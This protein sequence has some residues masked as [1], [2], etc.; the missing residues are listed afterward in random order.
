MDIHYGS[1]HMP[2]C[3]LLLWSPVLPLVM[4]ICSWKHPCN[5]REPQHLLTMTSS[6]PA[7][8]EF[9]YPPHLQLFLC[10]HL[11][12]PADASLHLSHHWTSSEDAVLCLCLYYLVSVPKGTLHLLSSLAGKT[13]TSHSA[14]KEPE[15]ADMQAATFHLLVQ[16]ILP[17]FRLHMTPSE[18]GFRK[19]NQLYWVQVVLVNTL[20]HHY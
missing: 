5:R 13:E 2:S 9:R 11:S 12:L 18:T 3:I 6:G 19:A 20:M 4:F 16:P 14:N 15:N 17:H 1:A 7:T 10:C 8:G